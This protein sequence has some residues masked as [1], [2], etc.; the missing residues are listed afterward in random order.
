MASKYVNVCG[1]RIR[2]DSRF[3]FR[4]YCYFD[5]MEDEYG[6]VLQVIDSILCRC[7]KVFKSAD[8]SSIKILRKLNNC[9]ECKVIF[10]ISEDERL[11]Y[12]R[13][14]KDGK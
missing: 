14:V 10:S 13:K 3:D 7:R 8:F 12:E 1:R 9:Y 6:M 5:L 2:Y 11:A 4:P